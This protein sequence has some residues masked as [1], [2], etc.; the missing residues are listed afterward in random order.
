MNNI[1]K[2]LIVRKNL[3][4]VF[5]VIIAVI[6]LFIYSFKEKFGNIV[7][8]APGCQNLSKSDCL[9]S[10][11]CFYDKTQ[12][13]YNGLCVNKCI[14]IQDRAVCDSYSPECYWNAGDSG[15]MCYSKFDD[16]FSINSKFKE[17]GLLIK[18]G[19]K[20]CTVTGP[21]NTVSCELDKPDLGSIFKV[22]TKAGSIPNAKANVI[23]SFNDKKC[24]VNDIQHNGTM[25]LACNDGLNGGT[26]LPD[27]MF[28]VKNPGSSEE[29][30]ISSEYTTNKNLCYVDVN[31]KIVCDYLGSNY[32][33]DDIDPYGPKKSSG[34]NFSLN[35]KLPE[36]AM[37]DP[38][39]NDP[40]VLDYKYVGPISNKS[41]PKMTKCPV[42]NRKND[43]GQPETIIMISAS[44]NSCA[45]SQVN[46]EKLCTASTECGGF[47]TSKKDKTG[48]NLSTL[49]KYNTSKEQLT[50][51]P[52]YDT[53]LKSAESIAWNNCP[54]SAMSSNFSEQCGSTIS[55]PSSIASLCAKPGTFD[56]GNGTCWSS[57][58]YSRTPSDNNSAGN[59][60]NK[61]GQPTKPYTQIISVIGYQ[62]SLVP[63]KPGERELGGSC[64]IGGDSY[65][66]G[67]GRLPD[68]GPCP[69]TTTYEDGTRNCWGGNL[70]CT[71]NAYYNC[72]N[73]RNPDGSCINQS[74]VYGAAMSSCNP[75]YINVLGVCWHNLDDVLNGYI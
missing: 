15:G 16:L 68:Y 17:K 67:A 32:I 19:D 38:E 29:I 9:S 48:L 23:L 10:K 56:K 35:F 4:I 42:I 53:Y 14:N 7:T 62:P 8:S 55:N 12:N 63:C 60:V 70:D 1:L 46:A 5:I 64:V 18:S 36:P 37:L 57:P 40:S 31:K 74:R 39:K 25:S 45:L 73:G 41:G 69:P 54:G 20:Y 2:K 52:D 58:Y 71:Q 66:R 47:Y 75:G 43:K 34:N 24:S 61:L 3:F 65:Y 27:L 28:T 49:I 21:L 51:N 6:I 50:D 72:Y 30:Y 13:Q 11:N 44:E 33:S 22:S 26:G 59:P